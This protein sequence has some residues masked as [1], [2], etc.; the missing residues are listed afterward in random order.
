MST[1]SNTRVLELV[2][3][4]WQG[5]KEGISSTCCTKSDLINRISLTAIKQGTISCGLAT[6]KQ[7]VWLAQKVS[8]G[9]S[10][11]YNAV[12]KKIAGIWESIHRPSEFKVSF[13]EDPEKLS[14]FPRYRE[15][16]SYF[17]FNRE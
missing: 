14:F 15:P 11:L 7:M 1:N 9:S 3:S 8:A 17:S 13:A 6:K 4:A 10:Y 5:L 16:N 12:A 2:S